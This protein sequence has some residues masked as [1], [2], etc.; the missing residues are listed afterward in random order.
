MATHTHNPYDHIPKDEK[1]SLIDKLLKTPGC[2]IPPDFPL[3]REQ[4]LDLFRKLIEAG[5][6]KYTPHQRQGVWQTAPPQTEAAQAP[7]T[8]TTLHS[9]IGTD[10]NL[11][12]PSSSAIT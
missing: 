7:Q 8:H 4:K 12:V 1:I 10:L 6:I 11:R 3:T 5:A 2:P 9:I